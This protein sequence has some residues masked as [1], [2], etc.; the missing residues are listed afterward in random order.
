M[1]SPPISVVMPV[2]NGQAFL[3]E[4]V[5]SIRAQT[6]QDF[7][8]IVVDDGSRDA[9]PEI[10]RHHAVVDRRIRIVTQSQAGVVAALNNGIA[11]SGGPY[12]ARMDADDVA[13]PD[14]LARQLDI[15]ARHPNVA[16]IGS[17]YDVIDRAGRV[18]RQVTMPIDPEVIRTTLD[19]TN[20]MAHS[21][22]L[23]R[24]DAVIAAGGYRGAFRH[25]EDY[26]LWLRLVEHHDLLN[27]DEPL[28]LYREHP[29]Q[30]TWRNL[31]QR[32]LSELGAHISAS[33]RRRGRPDPADRSALISADVLRELGMS[34]TDIR[35]QIV[36]RAL[37]ATREAR[38][39]GHWNAAF[40]AF[41]LARQQGA[42]PWRSTIHFLLALGGR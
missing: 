9:T 33:H 20:C 6:F 26:D 8:L 31:E 30:L 12:L 40:A 21:T 19:R 2:N 27:V 24:R 35:A 10:L 34:D 39:A 13:K 42:L 37:N 3:D 28:L 38:R 22:V 25:C 41:A 17:G 14:R 16:A 36:R 15:L 18:R 5:C 4:A 29:G 32:I 7:E 11:A 23:M 1:P